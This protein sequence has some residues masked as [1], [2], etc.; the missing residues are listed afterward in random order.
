MRKKPGTLEGLRGEIDRIDDALH[1]LLIRRA[2]ISRDVAKVKQP[3][4]PDGSDAVPALR[5]AREAAILR[6]LLARHS[7]DLPPSVLVR[8]WRE[9]I[10]ASLRVQSK[11]H[12]HVYAADNASGFADLAHAHFGS[13]TPI[14][15][16]T[17]PS[18]VVHAC[19]EEPSSIG[20]VPVP[21]IEEPGAAWWAQLAPAGE[22]GPRVVAKLPF[23][24]EGEEGLSA[25]A[26]GTVEQ[27]D[28]G[29]DTTLL[30]LEISPG[31]SRA[32]LQSYLKSAGL[33]AKLKAAG[34]LLEKKVPDEVLLE[35]KG[36][37][38]KDDPRLSALADA[39]GDAIIRAVPIGGYA[40]PVI[41][42]PAT[43]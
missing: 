31:I 13:L 30:L 40:N 26:I 29:D 12:L 7:G 34:R 25:Y 18:M 43:P 37:V 16:H 21:E 14:R 42:P 22:K 1:D 9:I 3:A 4:L 38:G 36:F 17:R 24:Q 33:K 15:T 5:P 35:V 2:E 6:R 41:L 20:I 23:V 39:A 8:I 27:E 32:S 10:A 11:F 28:S 19:A